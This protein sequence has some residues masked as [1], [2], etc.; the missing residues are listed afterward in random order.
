MND[1]MEYMPPN[2]PKFQEFLRLKQEELLETL[3]NQWKNVEIDVK[4]DFKDQMK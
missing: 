2:D 1:E 3:E 4:F